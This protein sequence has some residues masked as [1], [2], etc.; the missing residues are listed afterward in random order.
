MSD[1]LK[2]YIVAW[3]FIFITFLGIN[4][5][6]NM[7]GIRCILLCITW[8]TFITIGQDIINEIDINKIIKEHEEGY[9]E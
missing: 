2:W 7:Y 5:I 1:M 9:D 8:L 6:Y 3:L 4:I